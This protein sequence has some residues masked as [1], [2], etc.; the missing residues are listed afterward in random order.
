V[1]GQNDLTTSTVQPLGAQSLC[2]PGGIAI[3]GDGSIFIS[4]GFHNR[5]LGY[6]GQSVPFNNLLPANAL[7]G[8]SNFSAN[9]SGSGFNQLNSP[10]HLWYHAAADHLWV[11]DEMNHRIIRYSNASFV[12]VQTASAP[13]VSDALSL[14]NGTADVILLP[15]GNDSVPHINANHFTFF[16]DSNQ[17]TYPG[18]YQLGIFPAS[19]EEITPLGAVVQGLQF[20]QYTGWATKSSVTNNSQQFQFSRLFPSIPTQVRFTYSLYT[21]S[22][23]VDFAGASFLEAP[24]TLKLAI[25]IYNWPFANKSNSLAFS[26]NLPADPPLFSAL[27][28]GSAS[29][30]TNLFQLNSTN[31]TLVVQF[32]LIDNVLLDNATFPIKSFSVTP[33]NVTFVFP[34]FSSMLVY[35]PDF[36]VTLNGVGGS[37]DGSGGGS[38]LLPLFALLALLVIPLIAIVIAVV[39]FLTLYLRKKRLR[40]K[41][42]SESSI[43]F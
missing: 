6:Q 20:Q 7:I 36:T 31:G 15:K 14:D 21:A 10:Y 1:F 25:Q 27:H 12:Q 19:L 8:Q 5:V 37:G 41:M 23:Q 13:V 18:Q 28:L 17:N 43:N 38:S 2:S 4:D 11:G 3:T 32:Q 26:I 34:S 42:S 22:G 16:K 24:S 35:D 33:T 29:A 9:S 40:G 39:I 30:F